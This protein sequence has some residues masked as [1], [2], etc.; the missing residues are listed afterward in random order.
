MSIRQLL[1]KSDMRVGFVHDLRKIH[2]ILRR[3]FSSRAIGRYVASN[4]VRKLQLGA[5]RN[6]LPGWLNTDLARKSGRVVFLDITKPFPIDDDTFDYVYCEHMIE[7]ISWYESLIM[8]Q[9]CRR[10]LKPGGT[11]RIA[12]PDLEVLVGLYNHNEGLLAERYIRWK[13][14]RYLKGIP[15]Y[16]ASFVINNAFRNW[17]HQFLYDGD[18]L[19]MAMRNAGFIDIRRCSPGESADENLRGIERHG[20]K[21]GDEEMNV[22]ETMVFEGK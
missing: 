11:I 21:A 5:G 14:D 8:L 6:S 10:I 15:V 7:H 16:K 12:T 18:L 9:E 4:R 17:G 2:R 20:E 22:F 1:K 13:T 19:E 3:R